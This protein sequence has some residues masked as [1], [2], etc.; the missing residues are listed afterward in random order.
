VAD[1]R[2]ARAVVVV[3][4]LL[5]AASPRS[6]DEQDDVRSN[7]SLSRSDRVSAFEKIWKIISEDFYDN[8]FN[9]A[10]WNGAHARYR[11]LIE[12]AGSD[13]EFYDLL[14][15]MLALLR[16]SHTSFHR[17]ASYPGKKV[18]GTAVGFS[19]EEL[20]GK[21]VISGV[22]P[23][24][25]AAR[26]GVAPGMFVIAMDGQV[27]GERREWL[28]REIRRRVGIATDRSLSVLVRRFFFSGEASVPATI[29]FERADGTSFKAR[30]TRQV[31]DAAPTFESR[32]LASGVGY[33]RFKPWVPPN[34]TRLPEELKKL[35]DTPA[36]IIDLR[37][38][39]GGSF[40]TADYFL[41]P[42]TFTGSAV[43]R[44]GRVD[45]GYSRKSKVSYNGRLIVLVDEESGSA[46]DNFAALIQESGR[47]LIVGRQTCGCLTRSFYESVKGGGRLQWSRVLIRSLKGNKIEGAGVT[48]DRIVPVTL[49]D[50]RQGRDAALEE[51]ERMLR[52]DRGAQLSRLAPASLQ[53]PRQTRRA[54]LRS[55]V[56]RDVNAG[57]FQPRARERI[58]VEHHAPARR[59]RQHVGSHRLELPVRHVDQPD[60]AP[61]Q[62]L[63]ER[64][65]HQR[66]VRDRG[67]LVHGA[68][69]RH[70]VEDVA[71]SAVV[72]QR[73][74]DDVHAR[75]EQIAKLFDA[76]VIGA[77]AA[78]DGN[79]A[80]VEP[81]DVAPFD[82]TGRLDD[83]GNRHAERPERP[84]LRGRL[85]LASGLPHP[86]Q[87]DAPRRHDRRV[88]DVDRVQRKVGI[89][90]KLVDAHARCAK[91][92]AEGVELLDRE[93][94]VRRGREVQR[95]PAVLGAARA[96][97]RVSRVSQRDPAQ[98][99]EFVEGDH[100]EVVRRFSVV[101]DEA[102]ASCNFGDASRTHTYTGSPA[103]SN[104]KP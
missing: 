26:A 22:E 58:S 55:V 29:R 5:L 18:N 1:Q 40:M 41:P 78:A 11:P 36:L 87:H 62:P 76:R 75:T 54:D 35:L 15:E 82:L 83:A 33:I 103:I 70:Q 63:S 95:A 71:R 21:V 34:D 88:A 51:A 10:D 90:R 65:G 96:C 4:C 104:R 43:W 6:T 25:E 52:E 86:A 85:G 97:E 20:D 28:A 7:G 59:E 67:V 30:L 74:D 89:R 91:Q 39:R 42:G 69:D 72:R 31:A 50:L 92:L 19:V 12:T 79:R 37:G 56:D 77:V 57:R 93:S 3:L 48:P 47:G 68:H 9:G 61:A 45:K 8:A 16:D 99:T 38:N 14:D 101:S 98:L 102:E 13:V 27:V 81:H 66:R 60:S 84:A 24:S 32:R 64:N 46:S 2:T 23:A 53:R 17:P 44:G 100:G 80:L 94:D 49:P 73:N